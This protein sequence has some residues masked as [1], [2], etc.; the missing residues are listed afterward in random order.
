[1]LFSQPRWDACGPYNEADHALQRAYR[2]SDGLSIESTIWIGF[3]KNVV[4]YL[5][6]NHNCIPFIS[7]VKP[8]G[9]T[10]YKR[11][12]RLDLDTS[13]RFGKGA[14]SIYIY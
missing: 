14:Y 4:Q 5:R 12:S 7:I 1:M 8:L 11:R 10:I 2:R 13:H 3:F 6:L 9:G